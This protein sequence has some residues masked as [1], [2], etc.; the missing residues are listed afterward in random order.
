MSTTT[1]N[2]TKEQ[3][4]ARKKLER[5]NKLL[6]AKLKRVA[7]KRRTGQYSMEQIRIVMEESFSKTEQATLLVE[8]LVNRI[9]GNDA[10][11]DSESKAVKRMSD[12]LIETCKR[13]LKCAIWW[14]QR[15]ELQ[16]EEIDALKRKIVT[17]TELL[18]TQSQNPGQ[19]NVVVWMDAKECFK[20]LFS[21]PRGSDEMF[22]RGVRARSARNSFVLL[23]STR[24]S[25]SEVLEQQLTLSLR[26]NT[27][28]IA[29]V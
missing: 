23:T 16:P 25:L 10:E 2:L 14:E 22:V 26:S 27:G 11:T 17:E 13:S 6:F 18:K 21:S 1:A 9:T 5:E 7:D 20:L 15:V 24:T 19:R 4:K 8:A 28:T 29:R 12:D 3:K